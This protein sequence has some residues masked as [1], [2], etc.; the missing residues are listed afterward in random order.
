[1]VELAERRQQKQQR[2][3]QN[4]WI[5]ALLFW[6][7]EFFAEMVE[8]AEHMQ[9]KQQRSAQNTWINALLFWKVEFFAEMVELADTQV[10]EACAA[11]LGGSTPP[12]RTKFC[13]QSLSEQNLPRP[14]FTSGRGNH[15]AKSNPSKISIGGNVV[16]SS[17][18]SPAQSHTNGGIAVTSFP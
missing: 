12:L 9:E 10:S 11:R 13:L 7:V 1:M 15:L 16:S 2:S 5:N 3:A 8:L 4:T 14:L 17:W 18:R 6:K